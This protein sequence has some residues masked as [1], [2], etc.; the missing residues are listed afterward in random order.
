MPAITATWREMATGRMRLDLCAEFGPF[1]YPVE[2]K[3]DYGPKAVSDGLVQLS[4][5]MGRLG[6]QEGWL[7]V[8]SKDSAKSWDERITWRTETSPDGKTLHILG[9]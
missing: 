8:F 5:Y 9:C 4:R 1:R 6:C 7:I 2:L 3:I